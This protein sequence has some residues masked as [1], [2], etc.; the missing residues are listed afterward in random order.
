MRLRYVRIDRA[1]SC[2]GLLD[3][4]ELSIGAER[5]GEDLMPI[6]LI[7]KNG[8]GKSQFLQLLGEIFQAA[9][10]QFSPEEERESANNEASFEVQYQIARNGE[11]RQVRLRRTADG[12][13]S[14]PIQMSVLADGEW[15]SVGVT[16]H[17]FGENLP[18]LVVGYTS[19]DNETLSLPFLVSRG[20]YAE[21]VR[22]AALPPKKGEFQKS[23]T[24]ADIPLRATKR[25]EPGG[26][27][28]IPF[29]A[30]ARSVKWS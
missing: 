28:E 10:H 25:S 29:S 9:W 27:K 21:A 14:S 23:R 13:K 1:A 17:R 5:E 26:I 20:G 24:V 2:G 6:C 4:V 19:G 30:T 11:H 8:T 7:G 18:A 12:K 22:E 16:D 3:N 15:S